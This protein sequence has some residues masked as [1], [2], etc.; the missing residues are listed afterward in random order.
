MMASRPYKASDY[1]TNPSDRAAYLNEAL[2]SADF[3]TFLTALTNIAEAQDAMSITRHAN[4]PNMLDD[5]ESANLSNLTTLLHR[6]GLRLS[7]DVL[8]PQT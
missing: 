3:S 5:N 2:E 8:N 1:L 6:L 7:I 4:V